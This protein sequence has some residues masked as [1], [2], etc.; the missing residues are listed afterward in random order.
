M[1]QA[2]DAMR[3]V[4]I[5]VGASAVHCVVLDH[6]RRV[7][8]CRTLPA[9]ASP[10]LQA[11]TEGATAIAIDAP[12]SLSSGPHADDGGLSPKFRLARC[13]EIALGREHGLWVPWVAPLAGAAVPG[14][15]RVGLELYQAL[16]A[17]G[18]SPLEVYPYA[19]FR[20]LAGGT[21]PP[22]RKV[23]GLHARAALLERQGVATGGL[24]LRSHDAIDA[25][26]AAVLAAR[27]HQGR[28]TPVGCGH[29]RSA[30]W[31]PA[32]SGSSGSRASGS[33]GA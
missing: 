31:M 4:G 6:A 2:A 12:S 33:P 13:C 5:D 10:E 1:C 19:G 28:A 21:L 32:T 29:D 9:G 3:F 15:M 30:I 24:R 18:H 25:A 11:L 14:W 22:K 20:V 16:S 26:L 8:A 27:K 7:V 23:A 17:A